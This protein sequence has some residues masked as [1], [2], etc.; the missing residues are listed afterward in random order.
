MGL[1][2]LEACLRPVSYCFIKSIED[3]LTNLGLFK[4]YKQI[5]IEHIY[6]IS[7]LSVPAL[8]LSQ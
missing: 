7:P 8:S 4:I 3:I 5:N 1:Y 2:V 6:I